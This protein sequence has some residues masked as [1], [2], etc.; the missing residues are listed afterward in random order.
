M[1]FAFEKKKEMYQSRHKSL[2]AWYPIPPP[3]H[4]SFIKF[5]YA[6]VGNVNSHWNW[7]NARIW[8]LILWRMYPVYVK[9]T[10]NSLAMRGI[11]WDDDTVKFRNRIQNIPWVFI[12]RSFTTHSHNPVEFHPS[13]NPFHVWCS[14]L[15]FSLLRFFNI[16]KKENQYLLS[17][18]YSPEIVLDSPLYI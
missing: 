14:L 5:H 16:H 17:T 6:S 9:W 15:F 18:Y 1:N 4:R 13:W 8:K 3:I 2:I 12:S 11:I 7:F 10:P